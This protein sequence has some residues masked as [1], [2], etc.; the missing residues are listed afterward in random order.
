[1]ALKAMDCLPQAVLI[2]DSHGKILSRNR[3]GQALL[4][5]GDDVSAVLRSPSGAAIDWKADITALVEEPF[6]LTTRNVTLAGCGSRQLLVDVYLRRLP[7]D[8]APTFD[9]SVSD[10]KKTARRRG[11]RQAAGDGQAVLVVVEDVSAR[12]AMDAGWRPASDWLRWAR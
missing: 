6:G 2:V 1:M 11:T 7:A 8:E 4:P 3:A 9:L 12:A 10:S 5:E